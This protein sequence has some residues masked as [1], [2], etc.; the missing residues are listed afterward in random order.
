MNIADQLYTQGYAFRSD[1][2]IDL[3]GHTKFADF[4]I[5]H[6]AST[7]DNLIEIP[8]EHAGMMDDAR[9]LGSFMQ[10]FE[11]YCS[12]GYIPG[13]NCIWTFETA[14]HPLDNTAIRE[15]IETLRRMK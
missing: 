4:I 6:P 15:A 9:Y 7:A 3:F 2:A 5:L 8:W 13:I 1:A 11:L 10:K 12:A 14:G